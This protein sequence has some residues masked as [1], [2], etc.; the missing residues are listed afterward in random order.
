[1][2]V[3]TDNPKFAIKILDLISLDHP[4]YKELRDMMRNTA[5]LE[6]EKFH[7]KYGIDA[8]VKF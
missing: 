6:I 4:E 8:E 1:M 3:L 2:T 7:E 5:I